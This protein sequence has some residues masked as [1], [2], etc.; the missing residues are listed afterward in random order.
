MSAAVLEQL[1]RS[2]ADAPAVKRNRPV[3]RV[4]LNEFEVEALTGYPVPRLRKDRSKRIGM[5]YVSMPR[6]IRYSLEDVLAYMERHKIQP[7]D[8]PFDLNSRR[9]RPRKD[10]SAPNA[11]TG[12]ARAVAAN[13][14]EMV[15]AE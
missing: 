2:A 10:G 13:K 4:Y 8:K 1:M 9:G 11:A 7:E 14:R 15:K 12:I 5:P 3:P 6:C